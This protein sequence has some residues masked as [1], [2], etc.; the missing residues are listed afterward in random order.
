MKTAGNSTMKRILLFLAA[1]AP[2]Y[3]QDLRVTAQLLHGASQAMFG[4]LPKNV[5]AAQVQVCSNSPSQM[6]VPTARIVQQVHLA[7]G[8]TVLIG[9]AAIAVIASAQGASPV[10]VAL[11]SAAAVS[12][13]IK[14]LV[15]VGAIQPN[16]EWGSALTMADGLM[17]IG[18]AIVGTAATGHQLLSIGREM[19]PDPLSLAPLGCA[20]GYAI[21]EVPSALKKGKTPE[22]SSIDFSMTIPG[23]EVPI[24]I[25]R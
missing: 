13:G 3:A 18:A 6:T 2:A 15:L 1:L 8:A 24:S 5:R 9:D 19:L 25:G 23:H 14:G 7:N 11:R 22:P 16:T 21:L 10:Q 17:Q 4:K 12:G 20:T